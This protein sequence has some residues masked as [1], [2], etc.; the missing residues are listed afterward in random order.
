MKHFQKLLLLLVLLVAGAQSAWADSN[1][2]YYWP[3]GAFYDHDGKP[4]ISDEPYSGALKFNYWNLVKTVISSVDAYESG[5]TVVNGVKYFY[6]YCDIRAFTKPYHYTGTNIYWNS[7]YKYSGAWITGFEGSPTI[8]VIP[9]HITV[10]GKDY[11][12][13]GMGYR[14]YVEPDNKEFKT[15]SVSISNSSASVLVFKKEDHEQTVGLYGGNISFS[16]VQVAEFEQKCAIKNALNLPSVT[17]ITFYDTPKFFANGK[18]KSTALK[19]IYF[20]CTLPTWEGEYADHFS[21]AVNTITAHVYDMTPNEIALMKTNPVWS[22]FKQIVNHKSKFSY[23]LNSDGNAKV[24][25]YQLSGGSSYATAETTLVE[26]AESGSKTGT[27]KGPLNYAVVISDFDPSIKTATLKR[28]G[29]PVELQSR[30]VGGATEM[31]YNEPSLEEDV[32]YEA[33]ITDKTCNFT[34]TQTGYRGNITYTKTLNGTTFSGLIY[35]SEGSFICAQGSTVKLSI[36]YDRYTP[37]TLELNGSYI[38]MNKANGRATATI[39][40]PVAET[41]AATLTWEAPAALPEAHELPEVMVMRMGQGDVVLKD[42]FYTDDEQEM[43]YWSLDEPGWALRK[44]VN[45]ED[46]VTTSSIS[47]LDGYGELLG[48]ERWGFVVEATPLAGQT[49]K[50]FLLGRVPH[51]SNMMVWEDVMHNLTID[52]SGKCT[53][54]ICGDYMNYGPGNYTVLVEMGPEETA[55]ETGQTFSFVRKGGRGDSWIYWENTDHDF[56]FGEG[57]S[58][59][60]IPNEQL[61]DMQMHIE[62]AEGETFHVYKDGE[63]ITTQFQLNEGSDYWAELETKSAS[64]TLL[65]DDAPDANPTWNILQGE[66]MTGT[67]VIV[68]RG[69][70]D[71]TTT[72]TE[73]ATT[74]KIN[75]EGVAK[76]TLK[77]PVGHVEPTIGY[78]VYATLQLVD[79]DRKQTV[80]GQIRNL[81]G[82]NLAN[83]QY[84]VDNGGGEI[85]MYDTEAEA[86]A[87]YEALQTSLADNA[88]LS[89]PEI[90]VIT[91]QIRAINTGTHPV[92][93]SVPVKVIRNGVDITSQMNFTDPLYAVLEVPANTL[94]NA[95]WEVSFDTSHRLTFVRTGGSL[96]SDIQYEIYNQ[97][98]TVD[99][100]KGIVTFVDLPAYSDISS[101]LQLNIRVA[102]N[103]VLTVLRDGVDVTDVFDYDEEEG[104]RTYFHNGGNHT[105]EQSIDNFGFIT[106][107]AA[108]WQ[109][110]IE[111]STML[112]HAYTSQGGLTVYKIKENGELENLGGGTSDVARWIGNGEG[113]KIV[114]NPLGCTL[115]KLVIN[116]TII[117]LNNESRLELL[118]DGM[119][120]LTLSA[121]DIRLY[122]VETNGFQVF[123]EFDEGDRRYDVNRDKTISIADVTALVNKILGKD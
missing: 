73:S 95:T 77:V 88:I 66:G 59:K 25:L 63:D 79:E 18:I 3:E 52:S 91:L 117:D 10:D 81:L 112:L 111:L 96:Q 85:A 104:Y 28:N 108:T 19:D 71:E 68:T 4:A 92:A 60:I 97:E 121:E 12:V 113:A 107:E 35:T 102:D 99:I 37:K 110:N 75:D 5:Y 118:S 27:V 114:F 80:V 72:L 29:T 53:L 41:A 2:H 39:T 26:A 17:S 33:I 32:T 86:S 119:Y 40:V 65:I 46:A 22:N 83:G 7:Y 51:G 101:E 45:C 38:V 56:Y 116:T 36:P 20:R 89:N 24:S 67:Q 9:D 123:A 120:A 64:Y 31:Y 6:Y 8:I 98:P 74:M 54:D 21:A 47:D 84:F 23:S 1:T 44:I 94:T 93:D 106:R 11:R 42:F 58:S 30:T 82:Y 62:L 14:E 15:S 16:N 103:E 78:Q 87:R 100:P 34:L 90:V 43:D 70:E 122:S 115:K 13:Y 55:V 50:T 76:V 69:E 49:V 48:E 105:D 57:S 61:T 109:I